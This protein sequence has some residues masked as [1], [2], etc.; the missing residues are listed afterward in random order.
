MSKMVEDLSAQLDRALS[1][2][3]RGET[4]TR[5][6]VDAVFD[7]FAKGGA[8]VLAAWIVLSNKQRHAEPIQT[9]VLKLAEGVLARLEQDF[10][11]R[12]TYVPSAL[13]VLTLCG[14]A[15][16]LIGR[17]MKAVLHVDADA[18]RRLAV[19]LLPKLLETSA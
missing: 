18:S 3:P 13:L 7:A 14:F 8:G 6:L 11:D 19:Q 9:A 4:R 17:D 5:L 10:P 2:L 16:S 15:D 12:P 1:S